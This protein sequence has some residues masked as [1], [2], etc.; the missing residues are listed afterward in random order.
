MFPYRLI[1]SFL[2]S[3]ENYYLPLVASILFV[4]LYSDVI[5]FLAGRCIFFQSEGVGDKQYGDGAYTARMGEREIN[6]TET[7]L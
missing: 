3:N 5:S 2:L 1:D 6:V 7:V 4:Y